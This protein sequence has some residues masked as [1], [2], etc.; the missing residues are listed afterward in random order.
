MI[1]LFA[2]NGYGSAFLREFVDYSRICNSEKHIVLSDYHHMPADTSTARFYSFLRFA[3]RML[4]NNFNESVLA[5]KYRV[6]V[7]FVANVNS[8][9]F[10]TMIQPG[11]HGIISGFNQIFSKK[12]IERFESLVNFHP[13]LLPLYRGP[14][15]SY[16][17]IRNGENYTGFTLHKVSPEI[18]RGEIL[19]QGIVEIGSITDPSVLDTLIAQFASQMMVK[20]LDGI[21]DFKQ[22]ERK[23][24]N[25]SEFYKCNIDYASFPKES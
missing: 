24:I 20:Y 6:K 23:I 12:V 10:Y 8:V 15:P 14:V 17:C 21:L 5:R 3:K 16:W 11:D 2:N 13:S 22:L 9:P 7:S 18:D 19:Y 1:Y 25:A 4:V